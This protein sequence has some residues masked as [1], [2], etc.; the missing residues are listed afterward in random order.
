MGLRKF[1]TVDVACHH[2]VIAIG[3]L[4]GEN[5][6]VIPGDYHVVE[7][8]QGSVVVAWRDQPLPAPRRPSGLHAVDSGVDKHILNPALQGIPQID[9]AEAGIIRGAHLEV[10]NHHMDGGET[11]IER[12]A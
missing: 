7:N 9:A 11:A 5:A 4:V 3:M 2:N 10:S 12:I 8:R 1:Q 6:G